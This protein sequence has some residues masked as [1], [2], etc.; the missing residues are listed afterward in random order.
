MMTPKQIEALPAGT[1]PI[2]SHKGLRLEVRGRV[3]TWTLRRR[4]AGGKLK[5]QVVGHWP[6]MSLAKA[7]A[8][9]EVLR[10]RPIAP[11]AKPKSVVTVR[12][13]LRSYIVGHLQPNRKDRGAAPSATLWRHI[14][15]L[16]DR[17]A[18]GVGR[19]DAHA[20]I[21]NL[22]GR[23]SVQ[24]LMRMELAAAWE[25]SMAAGAL[26]EGINPWQKARVP[27]PVSRSRVLSDSEVQHL[28][29][30]MGKTKVGATTLDAMRL[31]LYTGMRSGEVVA[32]RWKD[33][34]LAAGTYHMADSKNGLSRVVYLNALAVEVL[35]GRGRETAFVFPTRNGRGSVEQHILVNALYRVRESL[36]LEGFT[37]HVLRKTMRTGLARLGVSHEVAELCLGHRLGGVAG[38]YNLYGYAEEQRSALE[39]WGAHLLSLT[40]TQ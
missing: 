11:G 37:I 19:A 26:P 9:C 35:R 25:W 13:V 27:P 40:V 1:Y 7:A 21:Q 36:G 39:K 23:V 33:I 15:E 3:K 8:E 17:D 20:L 22:S 2:S 24:R 28:F 6:A 31:T 38:I 16:A 14:G 29:K 4:D 12:E 5:Q 10:A 30:W 18:A 34:D 32:M